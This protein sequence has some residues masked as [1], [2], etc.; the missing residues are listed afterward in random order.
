[1]RGSQPATRESDVKAK[2]VRRL[3]CACLLVG[4]ALPAHAQTARRHRRCGL[5][6]EPG[7]HLLVF[8]NWYDGLFADSKI[9]GV[10][11]GVLILKPD[12]PENG[13]HWSFFWGENE[14]V[15]NMGPAY[16]QLVQAAIDLAQKR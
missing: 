10:V 15:I 12:F 6:R 13:E 4:T 1:M 7:R 9:S 5:F 8:S 16:I 2:A 11:P 3:I 14:Y